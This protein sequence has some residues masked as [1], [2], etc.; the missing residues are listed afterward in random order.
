[1]YYRDY[2]ISL[3]EKHSCKN[4]AKRNG[5]CLTLYGRKNTLDIKGIYLRLKRKKSA[6]L[7]DEQQPHILAQNNVFFRDK[8]LLS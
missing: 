6:K 5:I 4:E 2:Y 3:L 8:T 7:F 1:M